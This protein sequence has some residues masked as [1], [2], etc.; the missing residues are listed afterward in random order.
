MEP[1]SITTATL[2]LGT[3][4]PQR[5]D[6]LRPGTAPYIGQRRR[7]YVGG[8]IEAGPYTGDRYCDPFL[9]PLWPGF[10]WVPLCDLADVEEVGH[11]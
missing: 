9:E 8:I 6:D 1:V 7:W 3:F 4:A 10:G 5:T 2:I 11:L